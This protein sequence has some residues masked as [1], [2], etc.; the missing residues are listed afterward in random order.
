MNRPTLFLDPTTWAAQVTVIALSAHIGLVPTCLF[1]FTAIFPNGG[2][3]TPP[4]L[5]LLTTNITRARWATWARPLVAGIL[6][7]LVVGLKWGNVGREI[8]SGRGNGRGV[9]SDGD[10]SPPVRH[11]SPEGQSGLISKV[12]RKVPKGVT[13]ND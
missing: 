4:P 8:G 5:S 9:P 1:V 7:A 13:V 12:K 11:L 10:P 3:P 2:H 6:A